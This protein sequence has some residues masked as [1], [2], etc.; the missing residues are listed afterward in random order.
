VLKPLLARYPT[1]LLVDAGGWAERTNPDRRELRSRVLLEGLRALG[2]GIANVAVRDLSVGPETL[3]AIQDSVGVQLVSANLLDANGRPVFRPY[4]LLRERVGDRDLD[5]AITGVTIGGHETESWP[6]PLRVEPPRAA[7]ERMLAQ[8]ER[9]SD[10]QILLAFAP[11]SEIDRWVD[12]I[13][14]YELFVCGTGDLREAPPIGPT[15]VVL[16]PGT[17]CKFL[18]WVTLRP[19]AGDAIVVAETGIEHLDARV[20]DDADMAA[21]VRAFKLRI[22]AAQP[23]VAATSPPVPPGDR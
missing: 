13:P 5:I 21:R 14:G 2:L 4:V 11:G 9:Q 15:P 23:P 12:P 18:N 20:P 17:K 10:V 22:G 1:H 6:E 7:A 3:R 19:A 16:A 8:L